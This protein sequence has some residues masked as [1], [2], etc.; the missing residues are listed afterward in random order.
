MIQDRFVKLMLVLIAVLLFANLVRDTVTAT[1]AIAAAAPTANGQLSAAGSAAW[2][3]LGDQIFYA[4]VDTKYKRI[5]IT[6]PE[7]LNP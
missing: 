7:R 1:P 5:E 6:G 2:V 4:Q 3:L